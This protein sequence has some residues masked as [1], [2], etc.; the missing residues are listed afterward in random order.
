SL[1]QIFGSPDHLKG[2][3]EKSGVY[4]ATIA[5]LVQQPSNE[6]GTVES[7]EEVPSGQK[8]MQQAIKEA[9]PPSYVEQETGQALD[10][11]YAWLQ[12][13][14][15]KPDFEVNLEPI[16]EKLLISLTEQARERSKTLPPCE[17]GK[18][19]SSDF[20]IFNATCVP[21]DT[22]ADVVAERTRQQILS[23]ELF[24]DTT[25]TAD[26][27]KGDRGES[28]EKRLEPLAKAYEY[29]KVGM[30]VSGILSIVFV[31]LAIACS[32][33]RRTGFRRVA[34]IAIS[35]GA[36]TTIFAVIGSL[37]ARGIATGLAK[38]SSGSLQAR[39]G[40]FVSLLVNDL[41]AWWLG[42]GI[43]LLAAGIGALVA[44]RFIKKK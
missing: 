23:S 10:G 16:K 28:L 31:I 34:I 15:S 4:D 7:E 20:D 12:G 26:D 27:L 2:A 44:L 3:L 25:L 19:V 5:R 39:A 36:V 30:V 41:R 9:V 43:I 18:P 29:A 33:P 13:E 17:P 11:I 1:H 40:E 35:V 6:E 42:F 21:P 24:K 37:L 32:Q 38:S 14:K 22:T 8:A